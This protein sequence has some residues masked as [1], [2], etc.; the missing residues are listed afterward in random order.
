M[1]KMEEWCPREN[2]GSIAVINDVIL[3]GSNWLRVGLENPIMES[4]S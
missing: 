1:K 3:K 2:V 4:K